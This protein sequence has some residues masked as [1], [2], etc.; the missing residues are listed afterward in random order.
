MNL[1]LDCL[2]GKPHRPASAGGHGISTPT[3][4]AIPI[5][6]RMHGEIGDHRPEIS[7]CVSGSMPLCSVASRGIWLSSRRGLSSSSGNSS[8]VTSRVKA[9]PDL[10]GDHSP[11]SPSR[12]IVCCSFAQF[13]LSGESSFSA[14]DR[15]NRI[16]I[17]CAGEWG[18]SPGHDRAWKADLKTRLKNSPVLQPA[19]ATWP[20][21]WILNPTKWLVSPLLLTTRLFLNRLRLLPLCLHNHNAWRPLPCTAHLHKAV[22]LPWLQPQAESQ[23]WLQLAGR[24][25]G[26]SPGHAR[27]M[28][29][30]RDAG[31]K[32]RALPLL[33]LSSSGLL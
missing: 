1:S 27:F 29:I 25:R 19:R 2:F 9:S 16:I 26:P 21:L 17:D 32:P 6:D 20:S 4:S 22:L 24:P 15:I 18:V 13:Q 8:S 30:Q 14:R 28:Q 23:L 31:R 10:T 7:E 3:P 33:S 12:V 11:L 5:P